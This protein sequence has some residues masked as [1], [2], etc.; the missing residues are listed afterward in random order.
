M[1]SR[2]RA[3]IGVSAG[4]GAIATTRIPCRPSSRA[5][6][7]VRLTTPPF[8]AAYAACPI[9]PSYAAFDAVLTITPRSPSGVGS[10]PT[11]AAAASRM[12]LNVPTRL[13]ST[14]LRNASS[15][16]GSPSLP[17]TSPPPPIPAQL[18]TPCSAPNSCNATSTACRTLASSRTSVSTKRPTSPACRSA[19]TTFAPVSA[20]SRAGAAPRPEPPPVTRNIRPATFTSGGRHCRLRELLAQRRLPILADRRLRDLGDELEPVR[21]PPLR[22]ARREE[23]AELFAGRAAARPQDDHGERPLLPLLVRNRDH[24]RLRDGRVSDQLALERDRRD[25]LAAGLD[26]VLRAVLDL[27]EA[28]RCDRDD[29]AGLEPAVVRPAVRL[30]GRLVVRP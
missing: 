10:F 8:D 22:D 21:E 27:D 24:G 5:S 28:G 11:I 26:H 19:T 4:P 23:I 30:L 16:S 15:G 1:S 13:T 3:S 9:W 2:R 17:T 7:S 20:S 12:T 18:T 25:P 29:V 14:M 6:G